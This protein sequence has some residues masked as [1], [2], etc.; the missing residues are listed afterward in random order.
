MR[1]FFLPF[2]L[3]SALF[4]LQSVT[5]AQNLTI[6]VV[7]G[8]NLTDDV[9]SGRV[10]F[11]GDGGAFVVDPGTRRL[12]LGLKLEYQFPRDWSV[13]FN[14]LHRELKST[15]TTI[16]GTPYV[17]PDG[18]TLTQL[19]PF[20]RTLTTWE[21]PILAKYRLPVRKLHPF[22]VA[23]PSFRPAG[24]GTQLSHAGFTAGG[25]VEFMVGGFR[26]VPGLRYTRWSTANASEFQRP[27]PNQVEFL[28][29]IDRPSLTPGVRAFGRRL[30]IG[31]IA[32]I[33][34]GD[35][36]NPGPSP[37]SVI[38]ESNSGIFGVLLELPLVSSWSIEANGLYRPLHG[39]ELEFN[40][41]VR[42]AH[43]TWEFPVLLKRRFATGSRFT[44]FVEGG[45]SFRAEGN[46]NLEPVSHFGGTLGGGLETKLGPLNISPIVRYT[47]WGGEPI[48]F[49]GRT[50][51]HQTQI[52]V[53]FAY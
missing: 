23:G 34:L 29:G 35:D 10:Q 20:T 28:A 16:L 37:D 45:P 32:G 50:Q 6:G 15:T 14:A 7:A 49:R 31:V 43:L 25:G 52:L 39:S 33:G 42:F 21:F 19:G 46:L 48:G 30:S 47:Y 17:L 51:S 26:I 53:S 3:L 1:N 36:F 13:E 8:T 11:P 4:L 2:S 18:S 38:P 5:A 9:K 40:R 12:I 44:P 24:T 41:R 22:L 27:L